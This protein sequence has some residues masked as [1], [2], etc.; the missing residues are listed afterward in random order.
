VLNTGNNISVHGPKMTAASFVIPS[1]SYAYVGIV[2]WI[3][4]IIKVLRHH[5]DFHS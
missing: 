4:K 1:I 3:M 2:M 5:W